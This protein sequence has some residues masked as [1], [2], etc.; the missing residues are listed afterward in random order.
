[1]REQPQVSRPPPGA[2]A[3]G[4][5]AGGVEALVQFA[6]GLPDDLPYPVL[7]AL[8]MPAGAPSVLAHIID[9][10]GPLPATAA[11]D[12][13]ELEPGH[14]YVAVPNRHLM[15]HQDRVVVSQGPSESGHRPAIN[16][17]FRSVAVSCERRAVGILMSG[18]LD[19]GVRGLSAIRSRGGT[20]L[21]QHPDDALFADMPCH[22]LKAEVVDAEARAVEF[23]RVL[24]ELAARELTE[25]AGMKPDRRMELEN[26]IAMGPRFSTTLDSERLGPPSGYT[27]P[28]CNGSLMA[29]DGGDYRCR[30]GHAWTADALLRARDDEIERALWTA[31][32]S[33]EEKAKLSRTLAGRIGATSLGELHAAAAEEAERAMTLLSEHLAKAIPPLGSHHDE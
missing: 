13:E 22:A 10:A 25:E 16:A 24:T 19:D 27:C 5:S 21:V 23:G 11:V 4:A 9:R 8:H 20:T 32:R 30:V 29:V 26:R 17:L 15:V 18:V 2:V 14:I 7:V 31:I 12:G 1:M 3:V 33:L 6:G 28:D